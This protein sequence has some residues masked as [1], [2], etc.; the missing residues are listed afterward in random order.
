MIQAVLYLKNSSPTKIYGT[1]KV[2]TKKKKHNNPAR[3]SASNVQLINLL[4]FNFLTKS[5]WKNFK[6]TKKPSSQLYV[7]DIISTRS[8]NQKKTYSLEEITIANFILPFNATALLLVCGSAVLH[9]RLYTLKANIEII[10]Y[11]FKLQ[12]ICNKTS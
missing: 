7:K 11:A 2:T 5:M 8:L 10:L 9:K 4:T 3:T 6:N 1:Y 12:E